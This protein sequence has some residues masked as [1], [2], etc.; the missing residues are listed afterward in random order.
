MPWPCGHWWSLN[1]LPHVPGPKPLPLFLLARAHSSPPSATAHH[2][3]CR[4]EPCSAC[5]H[6]PQIAQ[7]SSLASTWAPTPTH[8]LVGP[9][10]SPKSEPQRRRRRCL[11]VGHRR[12]HLR[13]T[14][15]HQSTPRELNQSSPL[16]VCPLW[17]CAVTGELAA[18]VG[19]WLWRPRAVL[20]TF[21]SL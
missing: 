2:C 14:N 4:W 9:R 7:I 5:A 19:V 3:R 8:G 6:G 21:K 1:H 18:A 11:A 15:R 20:W 13:P 17:P 10:I 16:F 12:E